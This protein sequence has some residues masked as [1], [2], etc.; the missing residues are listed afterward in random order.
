MGLVTRGRQPLSGFVWGSKAWEETK[1]C[2]LLDLHKSC[3]AKP[4]SRFRQKGSIVWVAVLGSASAYSHHVDVDYVGQVSECHY[5]SILK[6]VVIRVHQ[7]STMFAPPRL[8]GYRKPSFSTRICSSKTCMCQCTHFYTEDGRSLFLRNA[9]CIS[10]THTV[11]ELTSRFI[12]NNGPLWYC[13]VSLWYEG[14]SWF[15]ANVLDCS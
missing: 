6:T 14:M 8:A 5:A 11:R 4:S 12:A 3:Y 10:Y 13:R 9:G 7:C 2:F 1:E 15:L